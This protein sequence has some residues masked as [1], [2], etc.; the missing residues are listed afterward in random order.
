VTLTSD[1]A[2]A[3]LIALAGLPRIIGSNPPAAVGFQ[4]GIGRGRV[5][6]LSD[7][8]VVLAYDGAEPP[9]GAFAGER[10]V[11]GIKWSVFQLCFG[12]VDP[13]HWKDKQRYVYGHETEITLDPSGR[14]AA[15]CQAA[16]LAPIEQFERVTY[17]VKKLGN[18]GVTYRGA[19][20]TLWRGI[21][22]G[23]RPDLWVRRGDLFAAHLRLGQACDLLVDLHF[24]LNARPVPSQKWKHHMVRELPWTPPGFDQ[25][26][27][28]ACDVG[29]FSVPAFERRLA[30]LTGL[31]TESIDRADHLAMLP[32]D[33]GAYYFPRFSR[34]SD[35][36]D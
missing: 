17:L 20:G 2:A 9:A 28:D 7:V 33:I 27:R 25:R 11:N 18:R 13:K 35:N 12:R 19:L 31:V 1:I 6:A 21:E 34:H 23:D 3:R 22:W 4:G 14:L 29:G 36:T 26:L 8:D 32:R 30:T 10:V 5:D 24:A 15:L 16:R